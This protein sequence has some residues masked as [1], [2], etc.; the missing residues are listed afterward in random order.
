MRITKEKIE[1]SRKIN[2]IGL[3]TLELT[4][5]SYEITP[6][7]YRLLVLLSLLALLSIWT[8]GYLK[9]LVSGLMIPM[10]IMLLLGRTLFCFP[11]L[12][13][14]LSVGV[15]VYSFVLYNRGGLPGVVVLL[16]FTALILFLQLQISV[17]SRSVSGLL[18][19]SIM[20]ILAVAAMNVNFLFPLSLLP[21]LIVFFT[22]LHKISVF[23]HVRH[24]KLP[25]DASREAFSIGLPRVVFFMVMFFLT[26]TSLFYMIPRSESYGI[27]SEA[28]RRRLKGFNESLQLGE[29][30]LLE[31][32]PAV[33][34]RVRPTDTEA[35]SASV[36]RR[37]RSK[38]LRGTTFAMY[39]NGR[40]DRHQ[41]RRYFIDLRK[42]LG[43]LEL[44]SQYP[45]DKNLHQ[46][47]IILENTD[48]PVIFF[49]DQTVNADIDAEF[50]GVESDRSMFFLGKSSARRRY[51]AR[52][53]LNPLEI[54]D[55]PVEAIDLKG[56]QRI[57]LSRVGI[58]QRIHQLAE[59]I[60]SGTTTIN[61]KVQKTMDWLNR[62]CLY[63][64]YE[65]FERGVDPVYQFLF[66]SRTG[67][68]E[69]FASAMT[70]LLRSM[71]VAARPV[72][73]YTMGDWNELGKFFTVRQRHAHTWVEVYFPES[74]WV[75]FDPSPPA[76]FYEP[77]GEIEKLVVLLWEIYEGQWFNYVYS[78][79]QRTQMMGFR[80]IYDSLGDTYQKAKKVFGMKR[81]WL[82]S[83]IVLGFGVLIKYRYKRRGKRS[84]IPEWYQKWESTLATSRHSWE[85]PAEFHRRIVADGF[86]D[87][88]KQP[89]LAELAHLVD[90]HTLKKENSFTLKKRAEEL[91]KDLNK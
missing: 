41:T 61:Q 32:N 36:V 60:A 64:L 76:D 90:K 71:R 29:G 79:D 74:G 21:Y 34:M 14:V 12:I 66:S 42:T 89:I 28:S 38:L 24:Y 59:Q 77:E 2:G 33:V 48:P 86:I 47:E 5:A 53:L 83:L 10:F 37:L 43:E 51:L 75:P 30:G 68:C 80:R 26:W 70:L 3:P 67:A 69:H 81:V 23:R 85:T 40:W 63:S 50:I 88:D 8:T 35:L 57:Y 49:P 54:R 11:R 84:W 13:Q 4:R 44:M 20:I 62:N 1:D 18:V 39:S 17:N 9:P 19:L 45:K 78:F 58:D 46:L 22:I 6:G 25:T 72:N 15:L 73:G 91:I 7:F 82:F 56:L 52:V 87:K 16:Q 55:A 27:A 31:D 65:E